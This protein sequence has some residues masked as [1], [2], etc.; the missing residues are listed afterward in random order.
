MENGY[1]SCRLRPHMG[2]TEASVVGTEVA[3]SSRVPSTT[4]QRPGSS[5]LR[6][7][8]IMGDPGMDMEVGWAWD[9]QFLEDWLEGLCSVVFCS[10][11]NEHMG[12]AGRMVSDQTDGMALESEDRQRSLGHWHQ[13]TN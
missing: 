7:S 10:R 5:L 2:G 8:P 3:I 12:C 11:F 1:I 9:Y 6:A 13:R 4:I